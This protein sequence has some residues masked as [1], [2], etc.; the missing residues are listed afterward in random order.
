[1]RN[2]SWPERFFIVATILSSAWALLATVFAADWF[3]ALGWAL[4]VFSSVAV[5]VAVIRHFR[6]RVS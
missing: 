4:V 3:V 1:M 6:S 5:A 2:A